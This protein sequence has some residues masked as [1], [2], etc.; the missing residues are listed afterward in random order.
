MPK[1][2]A[3]EKFY[4]NGRN[5]E[6][7]EEFEAEAQDV[8]L[9]TDAVSPRAKLPVVAEKPEA[10]PPVPAVEPPALFQNK[11]QTAADDGRAPSRRRYNRRDLR[12]ED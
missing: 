9:L 4:Y 10:A 7:G 5:M 1:L 2:I 3:K 6:A 12:S 11:D 8:A